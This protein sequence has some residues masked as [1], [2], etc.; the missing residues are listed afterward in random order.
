MERRIER[1]L[2]H[3]QQLVGDLLDSLGD[4]PAVEWLE[5][6]G[7]K[8]QQVEG[9]LQ[10]VGLVGQVSPLDDLQVR[11]VPSLVDS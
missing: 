3:T 11:V 4:G 6:D 10:Q 2:L 1:P 7:A 8:D 5:R 9:A